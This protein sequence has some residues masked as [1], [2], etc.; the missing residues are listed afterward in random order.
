MV[1]SLLASYLRRHDGGAVVLRQAD[2]IAASGAR[3]AKSSSRDLAEFQRFNGYFEKLLRKLRPHMGRSL[4]APAAGDRLG[5]SALLLLSFAL[6]PLLGVA[7]FPRTDPGQFV[8]NLKAPSGTRI[9]MTE[10]DM[11]QRGE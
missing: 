6:Y 7:Y 4:V 1:L 2:Q 10:Q 5:W 3:S 9:E 11:E 8:I